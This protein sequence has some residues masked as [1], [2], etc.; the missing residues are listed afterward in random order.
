MLVRRA[1]DGRK[2]KRANKTF[3]NFRGRAEKGDRAKGCAKG[4]GFSRFGDWE[5]KGM[6]PDGGEVRMGKG[7][8]E[9]VGKEGDSFGTKLLQVE[10]SEAVRTKGRGALGRRN[11]ARHHVV[12]KGREGVVDP[13]LV[14]FPDDSTRVR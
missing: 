9:K 13:Q 2:K 14:E 8:V 3:K 11:C 1:G 5:D 10:V 12:R 6:F 7:E 4:K